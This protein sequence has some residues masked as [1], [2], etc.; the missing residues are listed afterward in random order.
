MQKIKYLWTMEELRNKLLFTVMAL[1][2]FRVGCGLAVPF[3][4]SAA[5]TAMFTAGSAFSYLNLISGGALSKCAVFALGVSP[6]IN[7]SII[8]QLLC[9]VIPSWGA[10][11]S[12]EDGR[13]KMERYTQTMSIA[14]GIIMAT[15]YFFAIRNTYG[16]LLY[17]SGGAAVF[18]AFVIIACFVA[19]SQV[20]VWLGK[21]IDVNGIG[22]GVSLIIFFGILSR[23]SEIISTVQALVANVQIGSWW[24]I[25]I[26][27]GLLL[28]V[29]LS[30]CFVVYANGSERRIPVVYAK[31]VVGRKQYGGQ[32]SFIPLKIIMGGVLPII[33]A[34]SILSIPATIATFLSPT[35]HPGVFTALASFNSTNWVYCILYAVLIFGFNYFYISIQF[36]PVEIANNLRMNGGVIPGRRPG[37]PTSSYLDTAMKK[38]AVPGSI[39]LMMVAIAPI[40]FGN[41]VGISVQ[42]GGTSLLIA[43]SVADEMLRSL[44][45]YLEVR[46]HK[47]FLN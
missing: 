11:K 24:Y 1:L 9:V 18:E 25:F 22:N 30:I 38:L 46:N 45:S 7:A 5:L 2:L 28:F 29:V 19:G 36:D 17:P 37:H 15:G 39:I 26:G 23:W 14:L 43:V 4:N 10:L 32:S 8:V 12:D 13:K 47:G 44:N 27:L 40:I 3:I 34:N 35:N 16:A 21:L 31:K 41:A 6:Y 33:F 42:L 20:V